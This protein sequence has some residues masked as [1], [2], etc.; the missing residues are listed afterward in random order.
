MTAPDGLPSDSPGLLGPEAEESVGSAMTEWDRGIPCPPDF[1]EAVATLA[2][3][4]GVRP[5]ELA[6]AA[7]LLV[8]SV[9]SE[10]DPGPGTAWLDIAPPLG[11]DEAAVRRALGVAV[12]L[13]EGKR[14]LREADRLEVRLQSLEYRNKALRGALER[15][16]F[17]PLEGGIT[18]VREAARL[19][20]FVN[21]WC[22]DEALL[23]KRF[24]ELAPV[25]H[26]DTGVIAGRERM[27]QLIEA[28]NL[29]LDHVRTAY[30]TGRWR[31][32]R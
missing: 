28:R 30:T 11:S 14:P 3:R 17:Q 23:M 9:G 24:R 7:L 16:A 19:F 18:D 10:P 31:R 21:E 8:G 15:V 27:T 12:A 26:P 1:A 6:A 13:A 22:F 29:L 4:R 32:A 5:R 2:R 25:Y 20:G